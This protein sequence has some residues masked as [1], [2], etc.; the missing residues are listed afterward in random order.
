MAG[1]RSPTLRRR[2]L[3]RRLR[4]LRASRT[5]QDVA[6]A[7]GVSSPTISRI[8]TGARTATRRNV[9]ALCE[10]YGADE[11]LRTQ[12]LNLAREASEPGWWHRYDDIAI[13]SLIGLEIE[14]K[15]ITSY[16]SCVI[17]W[18]FQTEHYA[19]AVIKGILPRIDDR[20]LEERVA[21][22]MTRQELLR[23]AD[24]PYLWS[25]IDESALRRIVGSATVLREQLSKILEVA[26][27][28]NVTMQIVPFDAG[29]HPGL[30]NTFTLLEFDSSSQP[31][32]A[33]VENLAGTFYLERESEILRYREVL[34]YLR[35]SALSPANSVKCVQEARK[36][37]EG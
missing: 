27:T 22:R 2:E 32:I 17:S 15:R 8:E 5:I 10:L 20:I 1:D 3:G 36:A 24:P 11:S 23:S 16:E 33:Y 14:A 6:D 4:E 28:P 31:P 26:A 21:A 25:L 30:D 9:L 34:E 7:L 19:R 29:A 18:A 12:L 13:Q 37:L 35:A